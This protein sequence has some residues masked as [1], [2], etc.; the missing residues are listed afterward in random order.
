MIHLKIYCTNYKKLLCILT[1]KIVIPTA[2]VLL[3]I[4]NL[5]CNNNTNLRMTTSSPA[6]FDGGA[7]ERRGETTL[8]QRYSI[9]A[10][11]SAGIAPSEISETLKLISTVE[12]SR[13]WLWKR[14]I[15]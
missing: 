11:M 7:M 9:K 10:L 15:I 13:M 6:G 8:E 3:F 14:I 1:K 5:K 2:A 4:K 12:L